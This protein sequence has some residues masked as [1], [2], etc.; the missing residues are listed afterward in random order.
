LVENGDEI[1]IDAQ[2]NELILHVNPEE[3]N[4]RKEKWQAPPTKY[5]RGVLYKYAKNVSSA[6]KG[7]LTDV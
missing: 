6:S 7:C 5:K 3:L 2:T 1:T 4:A